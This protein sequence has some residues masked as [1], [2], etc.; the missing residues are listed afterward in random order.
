VGLE[1]AG[2]GA[3][4][5]SAAVVRAA[6]PE[7][8]QELVVSCGS[9]P[10]KKAECKNGGGR[11]FGVFRN[12]GECVVFVVDHAARACTFERVAHGEAAF[13]ANHGIGPRHLFATLGCVHR[14]IGS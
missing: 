6:Q 5:C 9:L 8:T 14:I 2:L 7:G 1:G 3:H 4:G 11:D 13:R 10:A 12:Q